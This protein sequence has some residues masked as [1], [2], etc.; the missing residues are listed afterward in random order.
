MANQFENKIIYKNKN[1]YKNQ[2]EQRILKPK[3]GE[4]HNVNHISSKSSL[5]RVNVNIAKDY[6]PSNNKKP[7][8]ILLINQ[9]SELNKISNKKICPPQNELQENT[10][11]LKHN[12][13]NLQKIAHKAIMEPI[14]ETKMPYDK[15]LK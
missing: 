12:Q 2:K 4:P 5:T 1:K 14:Q 8:K 9:N 11:N 3:S 13:R 10:S 15:K 6:N 7:E